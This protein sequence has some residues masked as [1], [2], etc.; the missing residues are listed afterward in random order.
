MISSIIRESRTTFKIIPTAIS[1]TETSQIHIESQHVVQLLDTILT[2]KSHLGPFIASNLPTRPKN[3]KRRLVSPDH[4][5][6]P[7]HY[8]MNL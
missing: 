5:Y 2:V 3:N 8:L 6:G 4:F 7:G 1:P